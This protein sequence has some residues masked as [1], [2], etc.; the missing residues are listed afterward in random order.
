[1]KMK[2]SILIACTMVITLLSACS[3]DINGD[4]LNLD[5]NI[6]YT[7][8]TYLTAEENFAQNS[9][10]VKTLELVNG[11]G[12][13]NITSSNSKDVVVKITKK[14]KGTD[15][16][17]KQ[18]IMEKIKIKMDKS[19]DKLTLSARSG[20]ESGSYIWDW[21]S[22]LY[23]SVNVTVDYDIKVP[24]GVKIYKLDNNAGNTGFDNIAGQI[25]IKQNA[26][27]IKLTG[28]ALEGNSSF[29]MNAGNINA[30]AS[31]DKA[32]E[33]KIIGTAGN[34][35]IKIPA[36]SRVSLETRLT[37]GNLTGSLLSGT[38]IKSGTIKQEINGG[39]TRL[40]VNLTAGNVIIDSK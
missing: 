21:V 6:S 22:K 17:T 10:G 36:S 4:K 32:D 40:I 37:A 38:S 28:V 9:D 24:E 5:G 19:G 20:D 8:G 14:V 1:M 34:I 18:E 15:E 23:K 25:N 27:D 3:V 31:V 33:V 12:N 16:K 13:I 11:A 2:I 35:N 7:G 39:G 29:N 30:D 26:G